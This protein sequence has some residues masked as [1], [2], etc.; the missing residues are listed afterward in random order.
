[1][2]TRLV[3]TL[4]PEERR[5][6]DCISVENLRDPREQLRFLLRQHLKERG[7]LPEPDLIAKVENTEG[8]NDGE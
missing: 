8:P 7:I 5:G 6:L 1:M 3:I 2:A 4:T